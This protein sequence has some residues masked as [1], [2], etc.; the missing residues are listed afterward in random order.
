MIE[1][2]DASQ[3]DAASFGTES[4]ALR[5]KESFEIIRICRINRIKIKNP[6][7]WDEANV[8]DFVDC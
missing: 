8:E 5:E 1:L 7:K 4:K 3:V 2:S 6:K